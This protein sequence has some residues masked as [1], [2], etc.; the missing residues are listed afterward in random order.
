M[1]EALIL[2]AF[3][4]A[5]FLISSRYDVFERFVSFS[6]SL[7]SSELDE[8]VSVTFFLVFAMAFFLIRRWRKLKQTVNDLSRLNEELSKALS[9][10]KELRGIIPICAKCKK[11]KDDQG[12]WSQIESYIEKHSNADFTHGL[13]PDCMEAMYGGAAL[14]RR[15]EA[16]R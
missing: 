9:E 8:I 3:G 15:R 7:E 16:E 2:L 1:K 6:R 14:V 13:C 10:I 11:V 12:Y 4:I 5:I